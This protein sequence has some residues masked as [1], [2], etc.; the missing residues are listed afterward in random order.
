MW[1]RYFR[2]GDWVVFRRLKYTTHPG[3]RAR[4]IQAAANGDLYNYFVEKFW[5]V[6]EVLPN[7]QLRL[8][9]RRG[10]LHIVPDN[11]P[12]L[13]RA[14]LWERFRYRTRFVRPNTSDQA[15]R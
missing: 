5:T 15:P 10:K 7:G 3:H 1:Y 14:S 13:R 6:E 4:S 9:T 2:P 8:R 11:D 12:N